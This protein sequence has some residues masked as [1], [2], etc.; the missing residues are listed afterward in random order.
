L[1]IFP[2][3]P[4]NA[5]VVQKL[6]PMGQPIDAMMVAEVSRLSGILTPMTR[7]SKPDE[8]RGM[9]DR[10]LGVFA[11]VAAH[12]FDAVAFDDVV[13]VQNVL[14]AG[15]GGDVPPTTMVECGE[16]SRT[17]RHISRALPTLTMMAEMPTM[18]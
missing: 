8:S 12:P 2:L 16:S 18:S 5:D 14:D 15:D 7:R 11:Q 3:P 4:K 17:M 10:G 1:R 13:G 9:A 6:Q